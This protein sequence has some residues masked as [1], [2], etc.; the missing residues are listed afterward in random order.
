M[1][2]HPQ[3][4]STILKI[5]IVTPSFNQ[6]AFL[7]RTA[8]SILSQTGAFDLQ[9]IVM[10]ACSTDGTVELLERL[11]RSDPRLTF[12]SER[13]RGQSHAINKGMSQADGD[14][15]AWLNAD[16]LYAPGALAAVTAAFERNPAAQWLVG[17][18]DI[19]DAV[20]QPIRPAIVRYKQRRLE[21]Y[22]YRTLLR[23]NFIP[24][25]AVFWRRAFG[26]AVGPLD[27]SLHWTMDYDLWLRMG[28]RSDPLL[29]DALL[30]RF[31]LHD[32]SK[33]GDFDR[34]QFDEGYE[35]AQRYVGDDRISRVAHRINVEKIV[36]A[37]RLM[38][39]AK[40]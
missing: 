13:D 27:E 18:Y 34:R 32:T 21:R 37:Y 40:L 14:I 20:D 15:V 12:T 23:E 24:Q 29:L 25:P 7:A 1:P 17:R 19:I 33:S 28:Q 11:S 26:E 22:A 4:A 2:S 3:P 8:D 6:G 38:R 35:V 10:D 30:A 31:R 36:W 39:L 9:W 16:D 5:S